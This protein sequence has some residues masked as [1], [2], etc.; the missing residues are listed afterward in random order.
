MGMS[1]SC[2]SS[3]PG[4]WQGRVVSHLASVRY[5]PQ[6]LKQYWRRSR[7]VA[8]LGGLMT[9]CHAHSSATSRPPRRVKLAPLVG[10]AG[11]CCAPAARGGR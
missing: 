9:F 2:A 4:V 1:C 7:S 11:A 6:R 10:A 3:G 5:V 8:V